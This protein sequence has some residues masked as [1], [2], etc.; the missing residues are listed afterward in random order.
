MGNAL[1]FAF[2][3]IVLVIFLGLSID[4]ANCRAIKKDLKDTVDLSTKAAALQL[5]LDSEKIGRGQFDIDT[6]KAKSVNE[7]II[8]ENTGSKYLNYIVETEVVN[9]HVKKNYVSHNGKTYEIDEPTVLCYIKYPYDGIF[10]HTNIEVNIIS[11]SSLINKNE[12]N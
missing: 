11:G 9:T 12:L 5:D 10:I 4:M 2:I 6:V 1:K 7:Q 8:K 3:S